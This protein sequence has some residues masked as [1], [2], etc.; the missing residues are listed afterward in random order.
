MNLNHTS[1]F[2]FH[3]RFTTQVYDVLKDTLKLDEAAIKDVL[4]PETIDN[5]AILIIVGGGI[6]MILGMMHDS[7]YEA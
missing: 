3:P 4:S 5:A 7:R 2:S 1:N 6:V